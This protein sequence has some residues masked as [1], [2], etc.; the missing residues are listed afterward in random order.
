MFSVDSRPG[1]SG[2]EL[3]GTMVYGIRGIKGIQGT[4]RDNR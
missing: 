1:D 2:V 4:Y 3:V